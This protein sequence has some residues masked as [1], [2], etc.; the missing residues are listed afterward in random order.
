M[1]QVL[2]VFVAVLLLG[3]CSKK[4]PVLNGKLVN[5]DEFEHEYVLSGEPLS[6]IESK[7][8][9]GCEIKYPYLFLNLYRQDEFVAVYNLQEQSFLGNYFSHG[10]AGDEYVDFNIVNQNGDNVFW[11]IDPQNRMLREY[12]YKQQKN[13]SIFQQVNEIK[14]K[15]ADDLFS[16]FTANN[17]L[18]AYKAYSQAKGLY[19][20]N[21]KSGKTFSPYNHKFQQNDLNRIMTL[22]DCMKPD[23]SKIVSLTGIWD[24]VDIVSIDGSDENMSITTSDKLMSW[25]EYLNT[26]SDN[27]IDYYISLPRCNEKYIVVLHDNQKI[28]ELFFFEWNGNG[29]AKYVLKEKLVDFAIDW[30]HS[31]IY[32]LT[33]N[34]QIYKYNYS[35]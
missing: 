26:N 7:G 32:G 30:E 1:K 5:V 14:C 8:F 13:D 19:L 16:V 22:A 28:H 18:Y 10:K 6:Y 31:T 15:I 24:E 20:K 11:T 34:E 9:L 23:G 33:E 2:L 4:S 25:N 35:I 21:T 17:E 27:F 12:A 3:S 29:K